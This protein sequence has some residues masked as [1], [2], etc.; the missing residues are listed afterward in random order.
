MRT[1]TKTVY[2]F[3]ELSDKAKQKARD[4]YREGS[5][6]DEY[7]DSI[8]EDADTLAKLMGIEIDQKPIRTVGGS[9]RYE[10]AIYFSGFSS[11]GDGAC[12]VGRYAYA[13]GGAAKVREHA[14][15]DEALHAIAD[16]LQALQ[17]ANGYRLTATITHRDTYYHSGTADFEVMKGDDYASDDAETELKRL[18]RAFM[19][20]IY[21]QLEAE[22]EYQ[23]SDEQVDESIRA[24]AY[25]FEKDGTRTRD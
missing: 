7:W 11:Q 21:R 2:L 17:K 22:Y 6:D 25:E 12:F 24:N 13:K 9:T 14:P 18:I 4:W 19:D 16:G 15:Q 8:Y 1:V 23:T 10:P 20:W 5:S 3:D